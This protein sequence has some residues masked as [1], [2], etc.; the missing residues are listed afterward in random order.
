MKAVFLDFDTYYPEKLN[1]SALKNA[2]DDFKFYGRTEP[3]ETLERM[4]A[5]EII[6]SKKVFKTRKHIAASPDL[7]IIIA[8]ATG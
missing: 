3:A 6:L 1:A 4:K 7:K 2:V 8:A 5:A